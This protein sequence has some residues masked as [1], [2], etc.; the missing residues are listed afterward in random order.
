MIYQM[1]AVYDHKA[2]AHLPPFF[3][4]TVAVAV[5][6]VTG[7]ANTPGHQIHTNPEDYTLYHLGTY[8]DEHATFEIFKEKKLITNAAKLKRGTENVE[9]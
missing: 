2:L 4:A 9:R 1:M 7:A 5:R 6:G 3:S 8:D